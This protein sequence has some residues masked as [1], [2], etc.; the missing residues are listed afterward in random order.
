MEDTEKKYFLSSENAAEF[1]RIIEKQSR[2]CAEE[3]VTGTLPVAERAAFVE[4]KLETISEFAAW[5]ASVF[6]NIVSESA[7]D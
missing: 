5:G 6:G 3:L 1:L 2:D 4:G 7:T